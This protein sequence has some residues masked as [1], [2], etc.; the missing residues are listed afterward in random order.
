MSET[1]RPNPRPGGWDDSH[2]VTHDPVHL[3]GRDVYP[4]ELLAGAEV[5]GW[6]DSHFV[7]HDPVH[8]DGRDV[9]PPE[10]LAWLDA[11]WRQMWGTFDDRTKRLLREWDA[12]RVAALK[13]RLEGLEE[14]ERLKE[15]RVPDAED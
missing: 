3:D 2:F 15:N 4:P 9:Y 12:V 10:L 14:Y 1:T 8:L 6:D 11:N 7:T 13:A 5:G